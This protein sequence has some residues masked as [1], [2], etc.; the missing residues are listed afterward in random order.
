MVS[1]SAL[2]KEAFFDTL[3][4]MKKELDGKAV[5]IVALLDELDET[6]LKICSQDARARPERR[7]DS[8]GQ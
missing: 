5:A 3:K 2:E 4:K 8:I 6:S 1:V 7:H